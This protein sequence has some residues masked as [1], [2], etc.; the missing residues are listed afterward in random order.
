MESGQQIGRCVLTQIGSSTAQ[1]RASAVRHAHHDFDLGEGAPGLG[2]FDQSTG[3]I[4]DAN[5]VA[6]AAGCSGIIATPRSELSKA[7]PDKRGLR[8]I[9][10]AVIEGE[11]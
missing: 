2:C 6:E 4:V 5:R 11:R 8:E 9:I 1:R 10:C 7:M 3:L